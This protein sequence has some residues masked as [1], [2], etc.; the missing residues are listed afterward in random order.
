[1]ESFT[2]PLPSPLHSASKLQPLCYIPAHKPTGFLFLNTC[3]IPYAYAQD[4]RYLNIHCMNACAHIHIL[5]CVHTLPPSPPL[6]SPGE[7][8]LIFVFARISLR[9]AV[10]GARERRRQLYLSAQRWQR[11]YS[12]R[13]SYCCI[14]VASKWVGA[15]SI[16]RVVNELR[17]VGIL[18]ET[19]L[20]TVVEILLLFCHYFGAVL[21]NLQQRI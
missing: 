21:P 13:Y 15:R 4:K 10:V 20:K 3:K 16:F 6:Y 5:T 18:I 1:M 14:A 9:S 7:Y 8:R 17:T 19:V 2:L 11:C 12:A